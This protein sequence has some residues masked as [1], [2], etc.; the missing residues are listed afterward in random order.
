M[1]FWVLECEHHSFW[2]RLTGRKGR[3]G[4]AF[5]SIGDETPSVCDSLLCACWASFR[6]KNKSENEIKRKD[7]KLR[8]ISFSNPS[9]R[10]SSWVSRLRVELRDSFFKKN[11]LDF[12]KT[13]SPVGD[14]G[15]WTAST[16][17][18]PQRH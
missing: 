14:L 9:S 17:W 8:F 18:M 11:Y 10:V 16:N 7:F 15:G 3:F 5:E 1:S 6:N 2:G 12:N 13:L 4:E